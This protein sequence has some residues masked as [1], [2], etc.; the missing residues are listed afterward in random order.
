MESPSLYAAVISQGWSATFRSSLYF[1]ANIQ[2]QLAGTTLSIQIPSSF[3]SVSHIMGIIQR[4]ADLTDLK[5][6]NRKFLGSPEL[7]IPTSVSTAFKSLP[8][9]TG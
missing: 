1:T 6:P 7:G 5:Q 8:G 3:N 2:P 4:P 9:T